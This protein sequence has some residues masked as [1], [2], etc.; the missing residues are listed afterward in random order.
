M[1]QNLSQVI[2]SLGSASAFRSASP[3]PPSCGLKAQEAEEPLDLNSVNLNPPPL[4]ASS[5]AG[6]A[7]RVF[8]RFGLSAALGAVLG[9]AGVALGAAVGAAQAGLSQGPRTGLLVA[10]VSALVGAAG[11]ALGPVGG[12]ALALGALALGAWHGMRTR[13][14]DDPKGA[15]ATRA[16][17]NAYLEEAR[18]ALTGPQSKDASAA[19]K[20]PDPVPVGRSKK[21]LEAMAA[22]AIYQAC[23]LASSNLPSSVAL[24]LSTRA[25]GRLLGPEQLEKLEQAL[26]A[27]KPAKGDQPTSD[28]G[29]AKLRYAELGDMG[30]A[31][32]AVNTVVIDPSF[33][34]SKD[35]VTMD[36]V[37]GHELSHVRHKDVVAKI[38]FMAFSSALNSLARQQPDPAQQL[39]IGLMLQALGAQQSREI[40]FRCDRE[41]VEFALSRGH[42]PE[43]VAGALEKLF[44]PQEKPTETETANPLDTHPPNQDRLRALLQQL[45]EES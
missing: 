12:G 19:E 20:L 6:S 28:L 7:A 14:G 5:W 44:S 33:A 27:D 13:P 30:P 9:P 45:Q 22:Q 11:L 18:L 31:A 40:E 4:Q 23:Q 39:A 35:A 29:L 36:F 41:G 38:G 15:E 21:A 25:A 37:V 26:L 17:A 3:L 24:S 34:Q 42:S 32:A 1:S 10:S 43:A 16:F 8:T 2:T